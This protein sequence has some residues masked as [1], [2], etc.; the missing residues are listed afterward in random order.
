MG[1]EMTEDQFVFVDEDLEE[2]GGKLHG[3]TS[4]SIGRGH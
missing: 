4:L 3:K 2:G 1:T